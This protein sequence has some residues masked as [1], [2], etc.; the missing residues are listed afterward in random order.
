MNQEN[1]QKI[2]IVDDEEEI[3]ELVGRILEQEGYQ[4]ATAMD[5][6]EALEILEN[7]NIALMLCDINMPGK[8]G[9]DLLRLSRDKYRDLAVVMATAVDDRGT[10]IQTLKM[11]AYGYVIKPFERNE[12][13]IN[14]VNALRRRELEIDNRRH[15]EE[16]ERL[17]EERT[18]EVKESREETIQRLAKAAEFRDNETAR[19]TVRMGHCCQLVARKVKLSEEICEMLRLAAPLHDVGKIGISDTILLKP[20]K[21]TPEEFAVIKEHSVIGYRILSGSKSRLLN[22]GASIAWTHHEKFDGSGYP[23]GLK[24][25]SIPIE[26]RIAAICDVFDALTSERVYKSS[27]SIEKS[28][29]ILKEGRGSHFDPELLDIFLDNMEEVRKIKYDLADK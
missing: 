13:I 11:D 14:I 16:L 12:L 20:A 28:L 18:A 4:Y 7:D 22:L 27:I 15:R 2:L 5:V 3:L 21:L 17:V 8:S 23:R 9:I 29:E 25:K 19:H 24:G 26:G 6:D 1:S 10:A